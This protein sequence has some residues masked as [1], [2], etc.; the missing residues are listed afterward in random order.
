MRPDSQTKRRLLIAWW[1]QFLPSYAVIILSHREPLVKETVLKRIGEM[2][3][4]VPCDLSVYVLFSGAKAH[5][6]PVYIGK[7]AQPLRR[8]AQHLDGWISGTGSYRAWR[9]LLLDK[10]GLARKDSTLLVIPE[11]AIRKP[12]LTGF[13][14]TIGSVEYQLVGL[15]EDAF[16]GRLLNREGKKR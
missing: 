16:P 10:A 1:E 3:A 2:A 14:T 5:R 4:G 8:W 13:P 12:P 6:V 15:A 11:T 9:E 7:A